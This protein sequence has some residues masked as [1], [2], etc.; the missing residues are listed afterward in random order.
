M[1]L[2]II[3]K[4]YKKMCK[5]RMYKISTIKCAYTYTY[6]Y[7]NYIYIYIYIYILCISKN[8]NTCIYI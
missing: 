7:Y 1:K 5:N 6:T 4:K 2:D 8:T 3:L